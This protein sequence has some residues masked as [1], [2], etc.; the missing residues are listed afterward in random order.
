[1]FVIKK[2]DEFGNISYFC[3]LEYHHVYSYM[4]PCFSTIQDKEQF[5][6]ML[7]TNKEAALSQVPQLEDLMKQL[8]I[9]NECSFEVVKL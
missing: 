2:T 3:C 5:Q 1:M 9:G 4:I 6:V 7:Y 8:Y